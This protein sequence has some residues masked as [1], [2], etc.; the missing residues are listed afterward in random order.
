[1]TWQAGAEEDVFTA[2]AARFLQ[3]A[4]RM[5]TDIE[6]LIQQIASLPVEERRRVQAALAAEASTAGGAAPP[7]GQLTDE[8]YQR[9]LVEAGLLTEVKPRRRDQRQFERFQPVEISGKPL[10]ETI[11]EE[12]R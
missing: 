7:T 8:A 5:A 6:K 10:S 3:Q 2:A 11:I 1:L 12:R 9:R 4:N